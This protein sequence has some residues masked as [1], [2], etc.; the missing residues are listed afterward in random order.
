MR[1]GPGLAEWVDVEDPLSIVGRLGWEALAGAYAVAPIHHSAFEESAA[2]RGLLG[3]YV[4]VAEYVNS[5]MT[6]GVGGL[7]GGP[8]QVHV[9]PA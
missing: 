8:V 2:R 6:Y 3:G 5:L 7:R 4:A 9:Q 1:P